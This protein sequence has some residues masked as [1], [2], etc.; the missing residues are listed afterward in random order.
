MSRHELCPRPKKKSNSCLNLLSGRSQF[1]GSKVASSDFYPTHSP[2]SSSRVILPR[3]VPPFRLAEAVVQLGLQSVAKFSSMFEQRL[4][5]NES[6]FPTAAHKSRYPQH[7][8]YRET[9][10]LV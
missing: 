9:R 3:S 7:T 10:L 1:T 6:F 8:K 2:I 4:N 5:A